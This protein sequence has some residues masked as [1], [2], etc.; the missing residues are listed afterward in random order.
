MVSSSLL[1]FPFLRL[2]ASKLGGRELISSLR[3]V[4]WLCSHYS[5][6]EGCR[7]A[8]RQP[9]GLQALHAELHRRSRERSERS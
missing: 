7:R 5:R 9:N 4:G 6:A 1:F 8:D 2:E 3:R